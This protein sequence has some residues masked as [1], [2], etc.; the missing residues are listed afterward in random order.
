MKRFHLLD[1]LND[2]INVFNTNYTIFD[3][4][5]MKTRSTPLGHAY[6]KKNPYSSKLIGSC[7]IETFI[8][9]TLL[10]QMYC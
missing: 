7:F 2:M 10:I 1:L 6:H 3:G 4:L 8:S 5:E 9:G